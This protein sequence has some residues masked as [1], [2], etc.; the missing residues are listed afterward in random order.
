MVWSPPVPAAITTTAADNGTTWDVT[1]SVKDQYGNAITTALG[2]TIAASI[3][4]GDGSI[5]PASSNTGSGSSCTFEY[6]EGTAGTL[7]VVDFVLSQ[8]EYYAQGFAFI[9]L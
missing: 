6:T 9:Q 7:V 3:A 5:A 2:W 1:V 8:G 4:S